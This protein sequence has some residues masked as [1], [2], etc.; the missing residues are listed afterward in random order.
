[1]PYNVPHS[2]F[3]VPPS[4]FE[5]YIL[6]GLDS[7]LA[8]VY[9]MVEN[10]DENIGR[11]LDR[12]DELTLAEN[13]IVIFL[14]DNGPNTER[15]NGGMKGRKGSVD[16]GGVRVP[17]YIKWP[18][19]IREGVTQQLAQDIDIMPSLLGLCDIKSD[20]LKPIDGKDLSMLIKG[21]EKEF[22]RLVFSRQGNQVLENCNS[23]VRNNR[24]RL[25]LT[26]RDTMLFDLNNDP[27]Q[28]LN[29]F[30]NELEIGNSLLAELVKHNSELI[31]AYQPVTTIEAG[32]AEEKSFTLPVQDA[33]LSGKIRYSSIHPNQSHTEGWVQDGDSVYWKLDIQVGGTYRVEMQ[34]GCEKGET[35][36]R[37][38]LR[39][40]EGS[41]QFAI[42]Q[43]FDSKILPERDYVKRTESVERT[44]AWMEAGDIVLASGPGTIALKLIDKY[45]NE[46]GLI[47]AVRLS[48]L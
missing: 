3:Q 31:S 47:K 1:V 15:Y 36:S 39:T 34:Y 32:F 30:D 35:G 17:F 27:D 44:W 38:L 11:I 18:G 6:A 46:A 12:L 13:T 28:K 4:Y 23:S 19:K 48:R 14:S 24:Y 9:G 16:E 26:R 42:D 2:P 22:N 25:V 40:R 20:L 8:S 33:T 43:P 7:T 29:V 45:R 41:V 5:K 37:F 10:M 21:K